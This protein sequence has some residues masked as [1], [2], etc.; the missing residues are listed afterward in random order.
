MLSGRRKSEER[1]NE[2]LPVRTRSV[3]WVS[4]SESAVKKDWTGG[5]GPGVKMSSVSLTVSLS[6]PPASYD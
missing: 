3:V 4:A 6:S 1:R 5:A 2:E